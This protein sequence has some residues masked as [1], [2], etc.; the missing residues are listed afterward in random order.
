MDLSAYVKSITVESKYSPRIQLDNPFAPGPPNPLL[1]AVKP[2][3]TL[4]LAD[5]LGGPVVI[6]PYGSPGPSKWPLI[7]IGGVVVLG[8]ALVSITYLMRK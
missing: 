2:Q 4:T 6:A 5:G 7:K 3:I 1:Q 8:I